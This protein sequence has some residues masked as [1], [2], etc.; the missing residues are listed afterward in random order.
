[1]KTIF[2]LITVLLFTITTYSQD[3]KWFL[4]TSINKVPVL[5]EKSANILNNSRIFFRA[6]KNKNYHIV[7]AVDFQIRNKSVMVLQ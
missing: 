5:E 2:S 6:F 1:M 4:A 7:K 3:Q